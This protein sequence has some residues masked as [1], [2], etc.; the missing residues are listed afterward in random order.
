MPQGLEEE[1]HNPSDSQAGHRIQ[2]EAGQIQVGSGEDSVV[3]EPLPAAE[4][5]L[6][7]PRR[8]PSGVPRS[9]MCSH[10]LAVCST[11]M[12]GVLSGWISFLRILGS[13]TLVATFRGIRLSATASSSALCMAA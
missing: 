2:G 6:R 9:R 13:L 1:E 5:A 12:L 4:G 10:L 11:V 3:V 7:A 8:H